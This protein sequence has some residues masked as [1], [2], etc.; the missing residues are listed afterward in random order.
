MYIDYIFLIGFAILCFIAVFFDPICE[1]I[2]KIMDWIL[3][4]RYRRSLTPTAKGRIDIYSME[5][6]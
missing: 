3:W 6:K 2:F 1:I 5:R 4:Q